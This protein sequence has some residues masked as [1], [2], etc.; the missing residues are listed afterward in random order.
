MTPTQMSDMINAIDASIE[1]VNRVH[2]LIDSPFLD[3]YDI[4]AFELMD[5]STAILREVIEQLQQA[6]K[7]GAW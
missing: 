3:E 5:E 4:Q 2:D 1:K 7:Q 6:S